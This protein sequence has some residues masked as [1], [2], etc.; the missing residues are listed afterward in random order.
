MGIVASLAAAP[1]AYDIIQDER[2]RDQERIVADEEQIQKIKE[3]ELYKL[4]DVELDL[5]KRY[6]FGISH[7]CLVCNI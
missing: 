7:Y 6:L 4:G 2:I 5:I 1:A 3:A